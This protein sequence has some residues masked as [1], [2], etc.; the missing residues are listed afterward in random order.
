MQLQLISKMINDMSL[1]QITF[2]HFL[3]KDL[4]PCPLVKA[5]KIALPI[6][7]EIQVKYKLEDNIFWQVE[8][9][10]YIT[11][12]KLSQE[13]FDFLMSKISNNC[14]QLQPKMVK[15][16]LLNLYH[17]DYS[18]DKYIDLINRCLHIY[19]NNVEFTTN[20]SETEGLLNRMINKYL[21]D[22]EVF[23]NEHFI[24]SMVE[25]LIEKNNS[26][27]NICY[28]MKKLNRIVSDVYFIM[29]LLITY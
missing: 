25:H 17:K 21:T 2:L 22:S 15:S 5:L 23:Y 10:G 27:E 19:M 3:L 18:T 8:Y 6:V 16:V 13:T 1:Q 24:N 7:F 11:K 28:I 29:Y 4:I 20:I 14:D 26:F 9:L 12:H